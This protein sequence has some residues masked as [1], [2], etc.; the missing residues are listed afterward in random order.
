MLIVFSAAQEAQAANKANT[1]IPPDH[2]KLLVARHVATKTSHK[3][4]TFQLK[5]TEGANVRSPLEFKRTEINWNSLLL[6]YGIE[7]A[8]K[9]T[10]LNSRSFDKEGI[11]NLMS[12][13][14]FPDS[15]KMMED[16]SGDYLQVLRRM[17]PPPLKPPL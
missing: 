6:T 5:G 15:K 4:S 10:W 1:I 16:S 14:V 7:E 2:E 17:L 11:G 8:Y 13:Y 12:H 3:L 9:I